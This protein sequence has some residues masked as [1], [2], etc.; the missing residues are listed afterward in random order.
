MS[1]ILRRRRRRRRRLGAY[2][3]IA[4]RSADGLGNLGRDDCQRRVLGVAA[5]AG[6]R[7]GFVVLR[8]AERRLDIDDAVA[9]AVLADLAL[10]HRELGVDRVPAEQQD[11]LRMNSRDY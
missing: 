10:Q 6:E 1:D 4:L 11:D 7:G 2:V 8:A 3:I 9:A 5:V